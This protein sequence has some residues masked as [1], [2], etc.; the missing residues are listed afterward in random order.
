MSGA[1]SRNDKVSLQTCNET[2]LKNCKN[3][4]D[5]QKFVRTLWTVEELKTMALKKMKGYKNL[6]EIK[7][8]YVNTQAPGEILGNDV[9]QYVIQ[10]IIDDLTELFLISKDFCKRLNGFVKLYERYTLVYYNSYVSEDSSKLFGLVNH[11][12][13][14]V[15]VRKDKFKNSLELNKI[16]FNLENIPNVQIIHSCEQEFNFSQKVNLKNTKYIDISITSKTN[17]ILG[18]LDK[19]LGI[20][21]YYNRL[22]AN[23]NLFVITSTLI[24]DLSQLKYLELD[25]NEITL[26]KKVHKVIRE[27]C[28]YLRYL[29]YDI[30]DI[31]SS[32]EQVKEKLGIIIFPININF[33]ILKLFEK[34]E[35]KYILDFRNCKKIAAL[36]VSNV[37]FHNVLI[38]PNNKIGTCK[39]KYI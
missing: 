16:T 12:L 30:S 36:S 25:I 35:S 32:K 20:N 2:L 39:N 19:L 8:V 28:K 1:L 15:I 33:V 18:K 17:F 5:L 38:N 10:F 34:E 3:H 27:K 11:K 26:F 6:K 23:N 31:K 24:G 21:I 37:N 29:N 4:E 9:T 22:I 13:K 14:Q 7:R